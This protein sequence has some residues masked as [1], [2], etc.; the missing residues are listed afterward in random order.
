MTKLVDGI[1]VLK[2]EIIR[3]Q[4]RVWCEYC[5]RYHYHGWPNLGD[6]M[7]HRVN[8]CINSDSPYRETDYYI[9]VDNGDS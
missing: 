7:T 2:G 6:R 3:I 8:H 1:P 5:N 9:E 4:V